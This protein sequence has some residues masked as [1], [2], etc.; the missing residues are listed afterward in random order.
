MIAIFT[1]RLKELETTK[2]QNGKRSLRRSSNNRE[3]YSDRK[4]HSDKH[5]KLSKAWR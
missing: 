1:G 4:M 2:I 5:K 3:M